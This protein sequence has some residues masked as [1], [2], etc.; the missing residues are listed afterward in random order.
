MAE[1]HGATI[2]GKSLI[3]ATYSLD[4]QHLSLEIWSSGFETRL[5]KF[6]S[7]IEIT[8][9]L[10]EFDGTPVVMRKERLTPRGGAWD[11]ATLFGFNADITTYEPCVIDKVGGSY[12]I[13]RME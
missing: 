1:L 3:L 8:N 7:D 9:N 2:T 10:D 11:Q 12:E 5:A 13:T 4:G 6:D